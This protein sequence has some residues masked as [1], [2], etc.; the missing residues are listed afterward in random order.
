MKKL[1]FLSILFLSMQVHAGLREKIYGFY[2]SQSGFHFLVLSG[3][4]T[5]KESFKIETREIFPPL[6]SLYRTKFDLCEMVPFVKEVSFTYEEAGLRQGE[7]FTIANEYITEFNKP[8]KKYFN[9]T[10]KE[11]NKKHLAGNKELRLEIEQHLYDTYDSIEEE[12]KSVVPNA[13][14][15]NVSNLFNKKK[16][17]FNKKKFLL[18]QLLKSAHEINAS[19][20]GEEY[21]FTLDVPSN[22]F[23]P[24]YYEVYIDVEHHPDYEEEQYEYGCGDITLTVHYSKNLD[25]YEVESD[26]YCD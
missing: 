7:H 3:G 13:F 2:T 26:Y 4:C 5:S 9:M 12:I 8:E 1:A 6:L 19:Q 20:E 17:S 21:S 11:L 16:K 23:L 10:Y 18:D 25:E 15:G 14:E 24:D 22:L